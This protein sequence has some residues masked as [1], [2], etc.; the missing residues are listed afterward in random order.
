MWNCDEVLVEVDQPLNIQNDCCTVL[1]NYSQVM[2]E[3]HHGVKLSVVFYKALILC[4]ASEL[5]QT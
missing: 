1:N 3:L 2:I 5:A 4:I